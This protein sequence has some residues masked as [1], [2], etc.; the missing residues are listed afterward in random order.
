MWFS[1]GFEVHKFL[2]DMNLWFSSHFS[3]TIFFFNKYKTIYSQVFIIETFCGNSHLSSS[4]YTLRT[5]ILG[6][7]HFV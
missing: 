6:H 4:T 2:Q 7:T 5:Q 1:I 3:R